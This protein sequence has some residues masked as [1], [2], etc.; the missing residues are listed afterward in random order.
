MVKVV[1]MKQVW[2]LGLVLAAGFCGAPLAA[3]DMPLS[4]VLEEGADW[5]LVSEGH[6]YTE[7]PAVDASGTIYFSDVPASK[8]Y[9]IDLDGTVSVFVENSARTNGLMFGTDGL[10]YGCRMEERQIVAYAADGTHTVVATDTDSNDLVVAPDGGI[11]YTD[12][13]GLRVW[14][15]S[16]APERDRRIVAEGF[17]PNGIVL[18]PDGQTLVVAD[19][20]NPWLWTYRVEADGS[21]TYPEKYYGPLRMVP[22]QEGPGSDGMT[23]DRFGRVYVATHAGLQMFDPTGRMG[24]VILKPQAK[25]LSNAAFGG[26]DRKY[27]YVTCSD[28]VYRRL[29]KSAGVPLERSPAP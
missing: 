29:T 2:I 16:P 26:K 28:R 24:G 4:Q 10:L 7:G 18:W 22:G 15:I 17:K 19:V 27:L 5:E 6:R 3:Q 1:A 20:G 25:K 8:I 23:V 12:P 14:Y 13:P 9:K 21:L 11:Y